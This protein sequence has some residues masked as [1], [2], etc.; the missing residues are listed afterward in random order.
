MMTRYTNSL[1]I[2]GVSLQVAK[3]V[4]LFVAIFAVCWLPRHIFLL[5]YNLCDDFRYDAFWHVFKQSSFCL[6]F[7]Y[8]AIN[9]FALYI[10][11]DQFRRYFDHYLCGR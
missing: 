3:I 2:H 1:S 5:I 4:L 6:T 11:N 8:S 10:I 9:P 7:I